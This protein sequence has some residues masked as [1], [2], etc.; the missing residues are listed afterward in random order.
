MKM[1]YRVE[2]EHDHRLIELVKALEAEGQR[3]L[4]QQGFGIERDP[5]ALLG[6]WRRRPFDVELTFEN[7]SVVIE[8]KVDHDEDGRWRDGNGEQE[9]QTSRIVETAETLDYLNENKEFRFITYG[10][11]EFYIKPIECEN[12]VEYRAGPYSDEF[13]HVGLNEMIGLVESADAVLP[14]CGCRSEWLRLMR[15][16]QEKRAQAPEMLTS[17]ATFREQ[18][19]QIDDEE[20]DFPRHRLL[21]CAPELAFPVFYSI[22]RQWNDSP[23]AADLGRVAIY[24]SGRRSPTIHDSILNLWEMWDG[25]TP[26]HPG[27]S[28]EEQ[29]RMDLYFEINE[30]FDLN[31]KSESA[32]WHENEGRILQLWECL[33]NADWPPFV[34]GCRRFYKQGPYVYYELDFGLLPNAEAIA[35]AVDNL[36]AALST[37]IQAINGVD[38]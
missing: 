36:A 1:N 28:R 3:D 8:T 18:Y 27:R 11:S 26:V 21:F 5:G 31:L 29:A 35:Q 33:D 9:W 30:D 32:F 4:L 7:L 12:G 22:A 14:H 24:P 38:W 34:K 6:A 2:R 10:T 17:F 16:E 25:G 15:V 23:H 37:A 13:A 20:N 19:L